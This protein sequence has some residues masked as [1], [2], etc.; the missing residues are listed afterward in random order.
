MRLSI[1][2]R[3]LYR[4]STPQSRLVQMLR[5]TPSDTHDQTIAAW[6]IDIDCDARLK[7]ARDGFGNKVTMLYAEGPISAIEICVT[8]EVLT[9][10]NAGVIDGSTERFPPDLFLRSTPLT[11]A[12]AAMADFAQA[13]ASG[14]SP[15]E[16]LHALN[17]AVFDRFTLCLRRPV[18]GRTA[19]QA[20]AEE[21]APARDLAHIFIACARAI[22]APARYVS[23]YSGLGWVAFDP[24]TG[25][26]ATQD[27]V[28]VSIGL[29]A[30]GAAP[31]AGSRLGD[32]NE[33]L[34]VDISVDTIS[35]G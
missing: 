32:G 14:G 6:R 28:R 27:Y 3:T 35:E 24:G 2:H 30:A 33:E 7:E 1:D 11:Q 18:Q 4:F 29:D 23:G 10:P 16:R 9:A 15:L 25:L 20:F 22:G 17:R 34:D 12:D 21:R 13:A 31:V 8:G 5:M 26:C 19:A